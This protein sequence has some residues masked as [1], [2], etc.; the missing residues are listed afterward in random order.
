LDNCAVAKGSY[1]QGVGHG[2][3]MEDVDRFNAELAA[4]A[5]VTS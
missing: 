1:Y 5:G 4:F 2:P 3:F